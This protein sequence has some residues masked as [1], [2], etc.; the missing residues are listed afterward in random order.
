[1][2]IFRRL[3]AADAQFARQCDATSYRAL[4]EEMRA[5]PA[6]ADLPYITLEKK[7]GRMWDAIKA[8]RAEQ[9]TVRTHAAPTASRLTWL[10]PSD[11]TWPAAHAGCVMQ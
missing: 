9:R 4:L 2:Y 3:V 8:Y 5:A 11:D 1:M 6:Y 7:A 10:H